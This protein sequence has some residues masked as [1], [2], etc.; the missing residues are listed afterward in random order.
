[1][2]WIFYDVTSLTFRFGKEGRFFGLVVGLVRVLKVGWLG[3]CL[4]G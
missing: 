4:V 2:T 3:K 1:M